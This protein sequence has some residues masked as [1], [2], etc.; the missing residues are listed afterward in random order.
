MVEKKRLFISI[1]L[2]Q[3]IKLEL[4]KVCDHF[5]RKELFVGRCI[6]PENMHLT[7]QF[8]GSVYDNILPKIDRAL[9]NVSF[10]SCKAKLGSLDVLPSKKKI[11]ILFA[12][13][14]SPTLHILAKQI[15]EVLSD[16]FE[17]E[18]R[19]FKTHITIARIKS[20]EDKDAFL[21]QVSYSEFAPLEFE[22]TE[23]LLKESELT[24]EGS[25]YKTV[26]SYK[27]F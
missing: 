2:P 11:K 27:L 3:E 5:A 9:K 10:K 19:D 20:I 21:E 16:I 18:T 15:E 25:I 23:F 6:K 24:P 4:A 12:N 8:L 7:L 13:L 1:E 14:N 26:S 17:S 22:I